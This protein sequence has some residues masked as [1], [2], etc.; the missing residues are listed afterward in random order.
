M[1][2]QTLS[3]II[4][5]YNEERTL[6]ALLEKVL[7]LDL[8]PVHKEIIV[9]DD[10]STD[11]TAQVA[12]SFAGKVTLL[13]HEKNKGKGAAVRTG[14]AHARGEYVV[15]Q[16]ADLE[17]EPEDLRKMLAVAIE[18]NAPVIYGSRN[19][20]YD[21]IPPK[22][23]GLSF[24]LGGVFLTW[25][26][27][28]LY[29]T[30]I[31]D[32]PT[33]YKM[34]RGDVLKRL[35]LTANGFEFC[36][37]IT[38][39][40]AL[41]PVPIIEV[42]IR[43][44]PRTSGEGKK[45]RPKDGII[46]VRVLV[47]NRLSNLFSAGSSRLFFTGAAVLLFALLTFLTFSHLTESPPTWYDEGLTGQV[48]LNYAL[49]GQQEAQVAPG[50]YIGTALFL[51]TGYPVLVPVSWALRLFGTGLVDVRA[52]MALFMLAAALAV[53]IF[54]TRAYGFPLGCA[55]LLLL[56]TFAPFYGQGKNLLGEVP[57]LFFMMLFLLCV[58]ALER[59]QYR[60][61]FL[62][63]LAGLFAG[64]CLAT[65]PIFIL[66]GGAVLL[67]LILH[68]RSLVWQWKS[69]AWGAVAFAAP[70]LLWGALTL[71]HPDSLSA[72]L[73]FYSNPAGYANSAGH[74]VPNLERFVHETSPLYF[75][76]LMLAWLASA[77][78]R[79]YRKEKISMAETIALIYALLVWA[80]FLRTQGYYRYFFPAEILA[81]IFLPSS[82]WALI[83][84]VRIFKSITYKRAVFGAALLLV[85]AVQ[86]YP[87]FFSSWTATHADNNTAHEYSAFFSSVPTSTVFYVYDIPEMILFLPSQNYYQYFAPTQQFLFGTDTLPTLERGTPD[88]LVT[89][90]EHWQALASTTFSR[91]EV[92]KMI[93]DITIGE[94]RK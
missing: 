92:L 44:N 36:P 6:A 93:G 16:D 54:I 69:L 10:G 55:S 25:L 29:G 64:L 43:Y 23:G 12:R 20:P 1:R 63:I 33:C 24:Y 49:H 70:L 91:Y 86:A 89:T 11:R 51:T 65:K 37:E 17:Y 78:L 7:A 18:Q 47:E 48:A 2:E 79:L 34:V 71:A 57:G 88:L 21:G 85:C 75:L 84:N 53:L 41:L 46:A 81:V 59:R 39:Q 50:Q 5:A 94:R 35:S 82:L 4:P 68:R 9:V 73:Q 62:Y 56:T 38:A 61:T 77:L 67:A 66:L 26:T 87:L 58:F 72:I 42:P 30:N 45:I 3:I 90:G 8:S 19:L 28:F 22:R 32:E 15:V 76:L 14:F 80:A 27:N 83:H 74:I 40:L 52:V 13:S 31:T 60:G